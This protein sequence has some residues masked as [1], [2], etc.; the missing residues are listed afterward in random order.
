MVAKGM[1]ARYC[2]VPSFW[3]EKMHLR[4]KQD[5]LIHKYKLKFLPGGTEEE[6]VIFNL[7]SQQH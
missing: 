4:V 7:Q 3:E 2:H 6:V 1:S 5:V